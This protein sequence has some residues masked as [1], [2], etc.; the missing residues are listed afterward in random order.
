MV[1]LSDAGKKAL[2]ALVAETQAEK[3]IPGFGLAVTNLDEQLYVSTGGYKA[4]DDPS[5]GPV[6]PETLFWLCSMTKLITSIAGL[7]LVEQGKI[8]FDEPIYKYIPEFKNAVVLEG[9]TQKPVTN[10]PTVG[11]LFSHS[12]GLSY[13]AFLPDPI[14]GLSANYV[15]DYS[16]LGT[17][18]AAHDKFLELTK[19][20]FPGIPLVNEPGTFSYGF[21]CDILA[22]I[23][24]KVTG[25]SFIDYTEEN[26]FNPIGIQTTFRL[27][28][29]LNDKLMELSFRNADGS[30]SRWDNQVELIP[31]YPKEV[32]FAIGGMGAY[33]TLP[34]YV[35]LLRHLLRIEAG[36][37]VAVPVLKRETVKG[38]FKPQLSAQGAA[39]VDALLK[40]IDATNPNWDGTNFSTA[41]ALTTKDWPGLR[42][43]GSGFWSGWAGTNFVMD[44]T[45]GIALVSGTQI[46]PTM[47][48]G[49]NELWNKMEAIVYANLED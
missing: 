5:S 21:S 43:A 13:F 34:D 40:M 19:G 45:T 30:I 48:A 22:M 24:E 12:S 31:R 2:D 25:Q 17:R 36:K 4:Y 28:A 8:S 7:Q 11:S 42:K 39:P 32:L 10:H 18:A 6:T 27:N 46:V 1:K 14:I 9:T 44:P 33:S 26:I 47:D 3:K 29:D 41:V 49:A 23:L 37:Q 38:M 16:E 35:T 20:M 15:F